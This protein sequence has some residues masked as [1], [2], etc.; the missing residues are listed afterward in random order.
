R[1]AIFERFRQVDGGV[2]R[3]F[4]GTGLGLSIAKEFAEL[5]G[6]RI[7]VEDSPG[8]GALFS[9]VLPLFAPPGISVSPAAAKARVSEDFTRQAVEE[10]KEITRVAV[11]KPI[12][13]QFAERGTVLVVED[14][15]NMNHFIVEALSPE[16]QV[17]SAFDGKEGLEKA[18]LARP[19]LILSDIM[20]PEMSG[21]QMVSEI[22]K[23]SHL[24]GIPIVI[25]T[26]KA[27]ED[28]RLH[29]LRFGAQDYLIKPFS[30]EELLARVRNLVTVKRARE[31]LQQELSS[32]HRDLESLA[33]EVITRGRELQQS[34]EKLRVA[35]NEAEQAYR[36]KSNF[37]D[38]VG[39]ISHEMRTPITALQ[40][41]LEMLKRIDAEKLTPRQRT[42]LDRVWDSSQ[43]SVI[44]MDSLLG[45]TKYQ[46]GRIDPQLEEFDLPSLVTELI[47]SLLELA[48]E[49]QLELKVHSTSKALPPIKSDRVLVHMVIK[50]LLANAIKYTNQGSIQIFTTF[51]RGEYRVAV[52]DTG[53]G[54]ALEQ[55]GRIFEPF[56]RIGSLREKR[57]PGFGLGLAIAKE[58]ARILGGRIELSSEVGK[59]S[60]FVA[61]FPSTFSSVDSSADEKDM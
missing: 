25:L 18:A 7:Q 60:I 17:I 1:D 53:P 49:K 51:E 40:L 4:G 10:L 32:Q 37:L 21:D 30:S 13:A 12:T 52:E 41:Q 33:K 56:E 59:G 20:M 2:T 43:R 15:I 39:L 46:S 6:G 48:Q 34:A 35:K 11:G 38:L 47:D 5:H 45:F 8:G 27:D 24:D 22:R 26:A 29:L 16:Y 14:N 28:L 3:R 23:R 50:N 42:L 55:Q 9:V 36:I 54:I 44:L 31:T 61:I 58:T 19:D 57:E